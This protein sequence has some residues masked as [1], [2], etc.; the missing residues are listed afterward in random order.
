MTRGFV[1][2]ATGSEEY[3]ILARNLLRSYRDNCKNP[4]KFALIADDENEYT[5]EFDDVVIIENASR[6]WM[7][8]I[9]LLRCCPYDENLFI[10]ADCL[11]YKDINFFWDLF[12]NADDF[13]CF[14]K[15]LP[16]DSEE[17]WF[18]RDAAKEYQ[19]H[20]IPHLHGILYFVRRGNTVDQMYDLC[21]KIILNYNAVTYKA[22]NRV[23]ADEPVFAL[24]MAVM[25][26]HP[27]MREAH[28]YCFVPFATKFHSNYLTRNV[29]FNNSTDGDVND[30]CIV[31]WGHR[32]TQRAQYK[33]D[34]AKMNYYR[35]QNSFVQKIKG[36]L[37]YQMDMF[38]FKCVLG[39]YVRNINNW[40][41]WFIERV[42]VKL[43]KI[44]GGNKA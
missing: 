43:K 5:K 26:L 2:I 41:K 40:I 32:N 6:S 4:M 24:A 1:T 18:T 20:F 33:A 38:Y 15:A 31:H 30:C 27:T 23:I 7:D 22:F 10:D 8:K 34:S 35:R 29:L 19:I 36:I 14:G 9:E 44:Y 11:V 25:N 39:E 3:Y 12:A 28:Y 42:Q 16:L 21:Q 13:S 17:G 37:L